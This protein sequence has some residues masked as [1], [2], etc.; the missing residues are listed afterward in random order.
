MK[1]SGKTCTELHRALDEDPESWG[2]LEYTESLFRVT[3]ALARMEETS[4]T[5]YSTLLNVLKIAKEN[6]KDKRVL[7]DVVVNAVREYIVLH[8]IEGTE[9]ELDRIFRQCVTR[10]DYVKEYEQVWGEL[11]YLKQ[12][13]P[14]YPFNFKDVNGKEV[15]LADLKG[16]YIY[17]DV[18]ATWCGPCNAEIPHLKELEKKLEGRNICFVGISC[19]GNKKIWEKFVKEK[20]LCG[21][22]L[23]IG[24]DKMFMEAIFCKGIPRFMLIDREGNYIHG[25]MS[26]PSD[27]GT[28]KILESLPG[29]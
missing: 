27:P 5:P 17:V 22:Q 28:L 9:E 18:W 4:T 14:A 20:G 11:K 7:E 29:L 26:R 6:F 21:L 25:K 24:E 23:H 2:I 16:K 19:D 3:S 1:F 15:R 8:G 13:A 10:P 12:G